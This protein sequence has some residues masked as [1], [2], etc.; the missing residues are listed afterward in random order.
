MGEQQ[1]IGTLLRDLRSRAGRSQAQQA[2]ALSLQ[3]GQAV[4]RHEVS[5]WEREVRLLTPFWQ[6]HYAASL[7]VP[8]EQLR[9]AVAA[10]KAQRRQREDPVQR[11]QFISVLAGLAL[12]AAEHVPSRVNQADVDPAGQAHGT[13]AP[14][15]Q[16]HGRR[17]HL[18][19]VRAGGATHRP[20]PLRERSQRRCRAGAA[21]TT[22][23]AD[24]ARRV[25]SVRRR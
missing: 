1:T 10:T 12:P 11:R 2:E 8:A 19:G 17:R 5:R 22:G 18:R 15:G 13:A 23:R 7:N 16:L 24:P 21:V 6:K 20:A 9:R 14:Y 3:A 25:G 4:T